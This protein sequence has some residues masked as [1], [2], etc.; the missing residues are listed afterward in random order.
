MML[1]KLS[2][3]IEDN[4]QES[5]STVTY[6]YQGRC[7]KSG[8]THKL[9]RTKLS[10]AVAYGLM[11]QLAAA[12][13]NYAE[14]KM[15]GVLLVQTAQGEKRVLKA[16]SGLLQGKSEVD[17]WV[18][19]ISGRNSLV[20]EEAY[21]LSTL[22]EIKQQLL[23]LQNIP[24]RSLYE[25]LSQEFSSKL[26]QL[27]ATHQQSKQQRQQQRELLYS[28][29]SGETLSQALEQLN[30]QSRLEGIERRRLKNQRDE[31]LQPLVMLIQQADENI[32]QLKQR[33]KLLSRQ[34]QQLMSA[35]YSLTNFLG[36][37]LSLQ[38]LGGLPT[39]T[40]ECCAPKLLHYAATHQLIPLAMA[41]FWWGTSPT[42]QDKVQGRFYPACAARCQP[43]MGFLLSGLTS[44]SSSGV[45]PPTPLDL[46]G[47]TTVNAK[48]ILPIIY[49]DEYLI[50]INKPEGLLS[51]PGRGSHQYD[52]V[53]SRI[54]HL[55]ADGDQCMVVHRLDQ[56]T[57]GILLLARHRQIYNHL[58]QQFRQRKIHKVYH[59]LVKGGVSAQKGTINLP[60]WGDPNTR[61]RQK[62]DFCYGKESI[63]HFQVI[64]VAENFT[65]LE[66]IPV[67]GRTHQ[68]RVHCADQNGLGTPIIGDR[69]YGHESATTRLHL[70][71]YSLSFVHPTTE[72]KVYLTVETP[73]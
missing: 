58:A 62:V 35:H 9:P 45:I 63:T 64:A 56:D 11:R 57:S 5:D 28:T 1:L 53:I 59:A 17:G 67:T 54:T 4:E 12:Q 36:Q 34:L 30:Q 19:S 68:I 41:E 55:L 49:E 10:E 24:E 22:E 61:P 66:F 15:Y 14:G 71:A 21:T 13:E 27:A 23:S 29:L 69:L 39:G 8:L 16:F 6:W 38:H 31:S 25:Q 43:L 60:L 20:L 2:D 7:Q 26:Q 65:R 48:E 3:F 47:L 52:S 42:H 46:A 33:R 37:S 72:E 32:R 73:F 40:G 18:G 51:V 50:A 44:S 70:H